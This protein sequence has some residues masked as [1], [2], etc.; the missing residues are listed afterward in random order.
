METN[1]VISCYNVHLAG[2]GYGE[3]AVEPS[4]VVVEL[5]RAAVLSLV[6]HVTQDKHKFGSV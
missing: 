1:I 3:K 6:G 5:I 4:N 2:F